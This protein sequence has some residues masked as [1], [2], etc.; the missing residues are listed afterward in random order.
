MSRHEAL[1]FCRQAQPSI[2]MRGVEYTLLWINFDW[3]LYVSTGICAD[4]SVAFLTYRESCNFSPLQNIDSPAS[5]VVA[6]DETIDP[7]DAN[8]WCLPRTDL[9]LGPFCAGRYKG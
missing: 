2:I 3:E 6:Q 1:R 8:R 7:L 9:H 4:I 5:A